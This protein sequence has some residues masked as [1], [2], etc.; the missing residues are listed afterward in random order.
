MLRNLIIIVG[1]IAGSSAYLW[2]SPW[3][4]PGGGNP[5]IVIANLIAAPFIV[6]LLAGYLMVGR[7][8]F[9][10]IALLIVPIAHIFVYGEDPAKPG[11]QNLV[12]LL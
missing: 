12:A 2:I 11:L 9:K 6:G 4:M 7:L 5:L 3:L 10:L 1:L 8:V